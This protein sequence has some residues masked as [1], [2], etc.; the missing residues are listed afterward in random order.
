MKTKD[1]NHIALHVADLEAS[2]EFYGQVLGFEAIPRPGFSFPGAWYRLGESQELHLI[3]GRDGAV[4]SDKRGTHFALGVESIEEVERVL[5]ERGLVHS[6]R[7]SRPDGV[8]Q[9]FVEDP[10]GYW[11][12]FCQH[13][14]R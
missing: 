5:A 11:V 13:G 4:N 6:P 10:D 8:A 3:G 14:G 9:I 1:L 12:E 7:R 2:M